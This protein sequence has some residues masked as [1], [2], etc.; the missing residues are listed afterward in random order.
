MISLLGKIGLQFLPSD[1]V[2]D[3]HGTHLP[4]SVVNDVVKSQKSAAQYS[5]FYYALWYAGQ[6]LHKPPVSY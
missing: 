1:C 6:S 4:S 2:P 3:I 5:L